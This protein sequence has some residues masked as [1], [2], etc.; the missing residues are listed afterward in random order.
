MR[1]GFLGMGD[2][3]EDE[4]INAMLFVILALSL[5]CVLEGLLQGAPERLWV[6]HGIAAAIS[7]W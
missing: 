6:F 1:K 5:E 4:Q 2:M 3:S 7:V